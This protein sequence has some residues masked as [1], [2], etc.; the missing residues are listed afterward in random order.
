[1]IYLVASIISS[2]S[3]YVIF[4]LAK[5]YSCDLTNLISFNY[6]A[7]SALGL[8][9]FVPRSFELKEHLIWLPYSA[10]VGIL[11]VLMFFLIGN[12]SQKAG[13]TVTSLA[14]KLSLVFPVLFSLLYF[15]EK[16]TWPKIAGLVTAFVAILFTV[17]KKEIKKTN[18]LYIILPL[19]IFT[20]SGITDSVVKFVQALKAT[21][22][23]TG[24]F[25]TFVFLVAFVFALTAS[26]IH[27]KMNFRK[28]HR[29]TLFLGILLGIANFGSLYFIINALNFSKINSSLVFALNN[30][31]IVTLSAILGFLLF[32]EKLIKLNIVGLLLAIVSLYFLI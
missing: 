16:L 5:N 1:M 27:N 23:Q 8:I 10:L 2:T 7:A 31:A 11:F 17:Y 22:G 24:L 6:F 4:R 12:S 14:N 26:V 18:L 25:S 32:H 30:M 21:P 28:L 9:F 15:Q 20:G 3:I 13:I 29:P 19:L